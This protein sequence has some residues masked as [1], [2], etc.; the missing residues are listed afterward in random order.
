MKEI[1][2][3]IAAMGHAIARREPGVE[4]D[5]AFHRAIIEAA[6]NP[7]FCELSSS[8]DTQIR[9]FIRVARSNTSRSEGLMETVQEEHIAICEAIRR[10]DG[11]AARYAAERHLLNAA[12]RLAIYLDELG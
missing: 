9:R 10:Q 5:L 3:R 11:L 8:M 1:D 2:E 6:G 4:E 7:C 12:K